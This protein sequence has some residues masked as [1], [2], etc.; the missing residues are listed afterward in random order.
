MTATPN[1][2][3][4]SGN[5]YNHRTELYKVA[6]FDKTLNGFVSPISKKEL[7]TTSFADKGLHFDEIHLQD[8]V[9][10]RTEKEWEAFRLES[11]LDHLKFQLS[12]SLSELDDLQ[13]SANTDADTQAIDE[14]QAFINEQLVI[15]KD[16][17]VHLAK[18][19]TEIRNATPSTFNF[20]TIKALSKS[21]DSVHLLFDTP[22]RQKN[23]LNLLNGKAFLPKGI[24]AKICAPGGAGKS[25]LITQ[26]AMSITTGV[27]FLDEFVVTPDAKGRVFLGLAEEPMD[28]IHRRIQPV[29]KYYKGNDL[30]PDQKKAGGCSIT[31]SQIKDAEERIVPYSFYGQNMSLISENG[32]PTHQYDAL[33]KALI[34]S[35]GEDG[36]SLI[37]LDPYSCFQGATSELDNNNANA[38]VGLLRLLTLELKGNPTILITHHTN[39][40]TNWQSQDW[41]RGASALTNG[42]RWQLNM[43]N[44][45]HL[46]NGENDSDKKLAV[47]KFVFMDL[48]KHND[49][50]SLSDFIVCKFNH[51]GIL[52]KSSMEDHDASLESNK[53]K[54][55]QKTDDDGFVVLTN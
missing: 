6:R 16:R 32:L 10:P 31:E 3:L 43:I 50:S 5:T 22:P 53:K 19:K 35:Q 12:K 11:S 39:K 24:V 14:L 38:L 45:S 42:V 21:K 17:E 51:E 13:T 40:S 36:Y 18:L 44:A 26:L 30:S 15:E 37:L 46:Q 1:I 34:A 52:T 41:S 8:F 54:T 25:R 23:L 29:F 33:R 7:V 4:I 2:I 27:N 20:Q 48:V 9:E 55:N 28:N 49:V 47:N